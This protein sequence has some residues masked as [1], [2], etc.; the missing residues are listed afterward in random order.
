MGRAVF[1]AAW[2]LAA[3]SLGIVSHLPYFD[4]KR[5]DPPT[6]TWWVFL[7]GLVGLAVAEGIYKAADQL[8][9]SPGDLDT[10]MVAA[11]RDAVQLN[12]G[13]V[14]IDAQFGAER[15]LAIRPT[16]QSPT[17]EDSTALADPGGPQPVRPQQQALAPAE[18]DPAE[19][20]A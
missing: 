7:L 19:P 16:G 12:S 1:V 14:E 5:F 17:I 8:R 10:E 3:L 13:A 11:V 9:V 15:S 6:W 4:G 18:P 20:H 2:L